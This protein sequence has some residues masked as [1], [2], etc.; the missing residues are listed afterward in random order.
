MVNDGPM[1]TPSPTPK[2]NPNRRKFIK[3]ASTLGAGAALASQS[4]LWLPRVQSQ[5]T[6]RLG[7]ALVGLG[8]LST[9]QIAPGLQKTQHSYLAGIVSGTP[10][11]IKAW[12]AKY[13]IPE[14]NCYNYDTFDQIADNP[15]IDVVYIVLP[16]G[17]HAEYTIRAAKA[18]KH[19]LCEKPMANTASDCMAMIEACRDAGKELAI[20]YRCQFEPHHQACMQLARDKTFGNLKVIDAG[21]GFKIGDPNQWRLKADL[22]GGGALMDVGIYALQACRYLAG[23]EPIEISAQE[24]KTDPVKFAEVDESIVWTMKFPSG[25]LAYCSTTYAF[26]GINRFHAHCDKGWFSLNPAY[27]Y[28]GIKGQ[29]SKGEAIEHPEIDQFAQEMD[30][31]SQSLLQG[32]R[33][34]VSG[35]E[36]WKDLKVIEAIYASIRSGEAIKL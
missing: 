23:E 31:F 2:A 20:G 4:S 13:Q 32:K 6:K 7:Y 35:E 36:G 27:S 14:K 30:D 5:E 9:H 29:T 15:D 19:V 16:N 11:K 28:G 8:G 25:V 26:S 22:A 34:R 12:Q 21:F 24:T 33:S 1:K 3:Q 10:S 17:M 18:G